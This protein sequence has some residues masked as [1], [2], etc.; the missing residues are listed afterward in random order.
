MISQSDIIRTLVN[1]NCTDESVMSVALSPECNLPKLL[2]RLTEAERF[3]LALDFSMKLGLD[4]IPLWRTW[5]MRCLSNKNFK[6]AR[7]KFRHCFM[8]LRQPGGRSSPSQSRLLHDILSCLCKMEET[9]MTLSEEVELIKQRKHCNQQEY[10]CICDSNTISEIE[11]TSDNVS[12]FTCGS[13]SS[14]TSQSP[15]VQSNIK[16]KSSIY[17]ECTYYI[18]EYGSVEDEIKFYVQNLLWDD[19]VNSLLSHKNKTHINLSRFFFNDVAI[20]SI[21]NGHIG[22]LIA[23]FLRADP[24]IINSVRYFSALYEFCTKNK[25]YHMLHYIQSAIGDHLAAADTCIRHFFLRKP[26]KNYHEL[27]NRID[28]LTKAQKSY[29]E[30]LSSIKTKPNQRAASSLFLYQ[31]VDEVERSLHIVATQIDITRNFAI[32]EVSG[33]ITGPEIIDDEEHDHAR[34]MTDDKSPVTLFSK[35][36]RHC[37]YLAALVLIYFDISCS[38]YLSK[39]GLDLSN[40]L[41]SAFKLDKIKVFKTAMRIIIDDESCDNMENARLLLNQIKEDYKPTVSLTTSPNNFKNPRPSFTKSKIGIGTH[42]SSATSPAGLPAMIPSLKIQMDATAG[43]SIG[44]KLP[45]DHSAETNDVAARAMCDA[46]IRDT[47]L[48]CREPDYKTELSQLLSGEAKIDMYI[49]QGKLS[50]AQRLAFSMNRPDYVSKIIKEATK[51][52]QNHVKTVCQLW[53][54]KHEV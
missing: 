47:I 8:R 52:N 29:Q 15:S 41:I 48:W 51:L 5:A 33:C 36:T 4:V 40:Q 45:R 10:D 39:S 23:A 21:Q 25:R 14:T 32:N 38:S 3:D 42:K 18:Q 7:D 1:K 13:R 43:I 28:S 31:P 30:Y 16:Y 9:R 2:E 26:T 6:A 11:P 17:A 34:V 22:D 24:E 44:P 46:I 12:I 20:R 35:S 27:N 53:L 37:T 54:A 50:N 19:A 49:E